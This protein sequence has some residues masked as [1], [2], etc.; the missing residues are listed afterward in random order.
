[1]EVVDSKKMKN[2]EEK[3]GRSKPLVIDLILDNKVQKDINSKKGQ[4]CGQTLA[5][6]TRLRGVCDQ[7]AMVCAG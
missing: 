7:R 1:M 3:N 4:A 6:R 2:L 5:D